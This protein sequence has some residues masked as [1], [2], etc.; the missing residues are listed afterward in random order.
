MESI[1][2]LPS[3]YYPDFIASNQESR[4][5]H[6]IADKSTKKE[7][8]EHIRNDIRQFKAKHNLGLFVYIYYNVAPETTTSRRH[9]DNADV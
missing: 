7:H 1:V 9:V 5:N 8:L 6:L 4:V 2:P 3:I